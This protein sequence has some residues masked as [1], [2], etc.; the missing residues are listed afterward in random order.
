M[1]ARDDRLQ[2]LPGEEPGGSPALVNSSPVTGTS[3]TAT[4]LQK[5]ITYYFTVAS[6]AL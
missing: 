1:A 3:F 4:G 6:V 2:P 5:V